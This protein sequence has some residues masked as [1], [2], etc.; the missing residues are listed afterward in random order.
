MTEYLAKPDVQYASMEY[1]TREFML[2]L[3]RLRKRERASA[4]GGQE[5]AA[6]MTGLVAPLNR[7]SQVTKSEHAYVE[8]VIDDLEDFNSIS[9]TMLLEIRPNP[10]RELFEKS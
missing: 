8:F 3:R 5:N 6:P 9:E 7:P 10:R 2:D 4:S 1:K